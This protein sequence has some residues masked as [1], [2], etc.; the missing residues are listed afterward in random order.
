MFFLT[1]LIIYR[2]IPTIH[3]L[4]K[5]KNQII[6]WKQ[7]YLVGLQYVLTSVCKMQMCNETF[8][9]VTSGDTS[10]V[11]HRSRLS[12]S[13]SEYYSESSAMF[14]CRSKSDFNYFYRLNA[15]PVKAYLDGFTPNRL[16]KQVITLL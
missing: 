2:L 1:I 15:S 16:F 9:L 5:A 10:R 4:G 7:L 8:S 13:A 3:L 6:S 11:S 14:M 12:S